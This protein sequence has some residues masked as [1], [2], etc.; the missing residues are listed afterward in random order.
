MAPGHSFA[1]WC[2]GSC[3]DGPRWQRHILSRHLRAHA[4]RTRNHRRGVL[5]AHTDK[6]LIAMRTYYFVGGPTPGHTEDFFTRLRATGGHTC[7]LA[8]FA[9]RNW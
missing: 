4:A 6:E 1:S 5:A 9:A 3:L 7:R 2:L 8:G